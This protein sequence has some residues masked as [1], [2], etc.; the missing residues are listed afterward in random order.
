MSTKTPVPSDLDIAQAATLRP[1]EEIAE[2]MGL[3]PE[4]LSIGY[5]VQELRIVDGHGA[6]V[7]GDDTFS[8]ATTV[9]GLLSR[10]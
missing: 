7:A 5:Q 3:L 1:I 8:T 9:A 6:R 2:K 4:L 10:L